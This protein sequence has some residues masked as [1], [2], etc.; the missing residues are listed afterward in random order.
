MCGCGE[1]EMVEY[2]PC[3][4]SDGR[5]LSGDLHAGG[6]ELLAEALKVGVRILLV[7]ILVNDG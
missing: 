4:L 5:R 6:E 3:Q 1:W 7:A 2:A